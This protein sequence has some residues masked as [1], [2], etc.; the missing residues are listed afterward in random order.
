MPS[1]FLWAS[2]SYRPR[3]Y[4]APTALLLS[5][6]L[7]CDSRDLSRDWRQLAPDLIVQPLRGAHLECITAHVD[8]LAETIEGSLQ[9]VASS[10]HPRQ[11]PRDDRSSP[12]LKAAANLEDNEGS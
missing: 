12:L 9:R 8:T 7:L 3:P 11:K 5:D 2:A 10:R 1:A 6:D 4:D